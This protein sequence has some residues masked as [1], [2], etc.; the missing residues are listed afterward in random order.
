MSR[1]FHM[2]GLY[3]I[4]AMFIAMKH[5]IPTLNG[6]SAWTPTGWNLANPQ[7]S[8]Y[9]ARVRVWIDDHQLRDVCELDIERRTMRKFP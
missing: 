2:W 9:P 4:D 5:D 8:D 1:S 6:Y 3:N 7:E